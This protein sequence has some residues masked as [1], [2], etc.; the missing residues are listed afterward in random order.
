MSDNHLRLIPKDPEFIPEAPRAAEAVSLL[1]SLVL[2]ADDVS[3]QATEEIQFIDQGSNFERVLCP[4]CG[5]DLTEMWPD[6][7]DK[8]SESSFRNRGI[9]APCC[10]VE[11]ELNNLVYDWPAGFARFSLNARNPVL[12]GWLPQEG[13]KVI[14]DVLGCPLRQVLVHS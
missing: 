9:S 1:A 13:Q 14:E 7:M 11:T 10:R 3:S 6:W 2:G 4:G 5:S 12:R 8:A